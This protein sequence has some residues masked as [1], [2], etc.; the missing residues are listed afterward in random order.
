MAIK[1]KNENKKKVQVYVLKNTL[2]I[3]EKKIIMVTLPFF[4]E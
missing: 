1:V 4:Y 2:C 3:N